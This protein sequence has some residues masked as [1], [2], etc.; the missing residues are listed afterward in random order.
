[1]KSTY[2]LKTS[3]KLPKLT[4]TDLP[5]HI[6]SQSMNILKGVVANVGGLR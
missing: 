4:H 2:F 5:T 6:Q 3:R 1:M